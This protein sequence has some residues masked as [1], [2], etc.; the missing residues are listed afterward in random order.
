M[1][2]SPAPGMANLCLLV[3]ERKYINNNVQ[4]FLNDE[5]DDNEPKKSVARFID[6][7]VTFNLDCGEFM[8]KTYEGELPFEIAEP[9][10]STKL[11]KLCLPFLD[12][13]ISIGLD[14]YLSYSTYDKRSDY[15]F[16]I[17]RLPYVGSIVHSMTNVGV[18][19]TQ[20]HRFFITNGNVQSLLGVCEEFFADARQHGYNNLTLR[21]AINKAVDKHWSKP[22]FAKFKISAG[23][24]KD[25][26]CNV[27]P[28]FGN[29]KNKKTNLDDNHPT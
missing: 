15:G 27:C 28:K 12:L 10:H 11:N 1:G 13:S 24:I 23:S 14:N 16:F 19:C 2:I 26:L 20:I 5:L 17:N 25:K 18:V 22:E 6:D 7:V 29:D 4:V 8:T 21:K 9:E 3:F